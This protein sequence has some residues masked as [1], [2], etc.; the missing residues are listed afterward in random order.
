[1]PGLGNLA[2]NEPVFRRL[3]PDHEKGRMQT[4]G[5][6]LIEDFRCRRLARTVVEGENIFA[7]LQRQRR[8]LPQVPKAVI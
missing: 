1:M 3:A 2:R 6:E 8:K 5:A 7:L 4:S